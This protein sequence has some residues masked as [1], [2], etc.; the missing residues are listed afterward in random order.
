MKEAKILKDVEKEVEAI[1]LHLQ[2]IKDYYKKYPLAIKEGI[3]QFQLKDFPDREFIEDDIDNFKFRIY[4][5]IIEAKKRS[6]E[7]A[8]KKYLENKRKFK[9]L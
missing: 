6:K 2:A 4:T 8:K 5:L 7:T 3:R 9:Q 1:F